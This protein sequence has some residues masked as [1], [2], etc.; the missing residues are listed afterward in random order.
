VGL[1]VIIR[2][3]KGM[4]SRGSEDTEGVGVEDGGVKKYKSSCRRF[5]EKLNKK[6]YEKVCFIIFH[7]IIFHMK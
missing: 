4:N 3:E 1:S 5:S 7:V 6:K 2:E